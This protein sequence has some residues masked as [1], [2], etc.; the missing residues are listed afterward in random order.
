MDLCTKVYNFSLVYVFPNWQTLPTP[1]LKH[2]IFSHC[3]TCG[4]GRSICSLKSL[5]CSAVVTFNNC[6][7]R[8]EE[9]G[10]WKRKAGKTSHS[11]TPSR[12]IN[13]SISEEAVYETCVWR[14][15][16]VHDYSKLAYLIMIYF[17]LDSVIVFMWIF[18]STSSSRYCD[19]SSITPSFP[20][21]VSDLSKVNSRKKYSL[22]LPINPQDIWGGQFF[23]HPVVLLHCPFMN[24]CQDNNIQYV[25]KD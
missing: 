2:R 17:H 22:L 8:A 15:S 5:V 18:L 4:S 19:L 1:P 20:G 14:H 12:F 11:I 9:S 23:P 3:Q 24:Q 21:G 7:F 25:Y 6:I 16:A 13:S 10:L